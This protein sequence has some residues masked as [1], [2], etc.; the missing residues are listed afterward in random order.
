MAT[1][2]SSKT[3]TCFYVSKPALLT[4]MALST[5]EGC[6]GGMSMILLIL[7]GNLTQEIPLVLLFS[8]VVN[9]PMCIHCNLETS[10]IK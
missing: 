8:M 3:H 10:V 6:Y 9:N 4:K 5:Q 2:Y 7:L 1:S